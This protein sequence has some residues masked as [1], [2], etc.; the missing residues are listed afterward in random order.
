MET[1]GRKK[2]LYEKTY[3]LLLIV[4]GFSSCVSHKIYI[5]DYSEKI[6]IVKNSFPEIYDLY[7]KGEVIIESVYR[8]TKDGKMHIEYYYR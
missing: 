7:R 5:S 3:F 8:D 2:I 4:I 6:R 1:G